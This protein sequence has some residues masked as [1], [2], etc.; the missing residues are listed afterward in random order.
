MATTTLTNTRT[1]TRSLTR[2]AIAAVLG[3]VVVAVGALLGPRAAFGSLMLY[4]LA[5]FAGLP[6]FA[7]IPGLPMGAARI[8]GPT[9]GYLLVF[10]IAAAVTGWLVQGREGRFLVT[11]GA[12]AV[13][14]VIIHLGGVSMLLAQTGGTGKAFAFG[15]VPFLVNDVLKCLAI[16][17]LGALTGRQAL[18]WLMGGSPR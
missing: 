12:A 13:G 8:I 4:L 11:L 6:V 2:E 7:N 10:P 17:G 15:V 5:G 18:A 1:P 9:G 14:M 16:A 3:A